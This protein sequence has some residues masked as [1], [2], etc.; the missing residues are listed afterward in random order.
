[1][2]YEV[3]TIGSFDLVLLGLGE[4]G[5]TASLFPS[6]DWGEGQESADALPVFNAPKPPPERVSLSAQRLGK[7]EQ[8][9]F[10]VTG[11][12]K[13]EAVSRW[14]AGDPIP[15]SA[16]HPANGVDVLLTTES[17]PAGVHSCR[18]TSYNVCY[19]KLLRPFFMM[20]R[21]N[22]SVTGITW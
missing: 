21:P 17:H 5:H 19:T 18:I 8:V 22:S 2:L 3:I 11:A 15:A 9:L 1:M 7:A 20:I 16:I 4:D 13:R 14:Q 12:G 10:L 6:Q